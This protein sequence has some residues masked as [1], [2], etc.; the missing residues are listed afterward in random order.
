MF[1]N[2]TERFLRISYLRQEGS[3]E[4]IKEHRELDRVKYKIM[5]V[6]KRKE[7]E[8]DTLKKITFSHSQL[9]VTR[10]GRR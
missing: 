6:E 3:R 1:C 2:V 7:G 4:V 8:R 10:V 9:G 5:R